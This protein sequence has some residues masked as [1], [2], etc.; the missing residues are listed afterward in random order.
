MDDEQLRVGDRV[1]LANVALGRPFDN[2]LQLTFTKS[3]LLKCKMKQCATPE[4]LARSDSLEL[5]EAQRTTSLRP[6]S[7]RFGPPREFNV[8]CYLLKTVSGKSKRNQNMFDVLNFIVLTPDQNLACIQVAEIGF[9][10]QSA[11]PKENSYVRISNI[12]FVNCT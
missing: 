1:S 2:M 4:M 5:S 3:S 11:F 6:S 12:Q 9:I 8:D 7:E 10:L